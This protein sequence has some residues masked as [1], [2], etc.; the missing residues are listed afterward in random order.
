MKNRELYKFGMDWLNGV[1]PVYDVDEVFKLLEMFSGKLR[2]DRW[3]LTSSGKY[4][5]SRRFCLDGQ[6][7]IQL[8]Y[9]PVSSEELFTACRSINDDTVPVE[10]THNNS[11]IFFSISGDGIRYLHSL[12]GDISALN[13]LLFYFYRNNFRASRFD[14]YCDI[15]DKD[16]EIVPLIT[17][18]FKNFG[19]ETVGQYAISTNVQHKR[20]N[21]SMYRGLDDN[22]N[23][24]YNSTLGN[25]GTRFGMFRSYNKLVE[26]CD[27][28]L[29]AHSSDIFS[30]YGVDSYWYRLEYELHKENAA[31][32]FNALMSKAE[33]ENTP[34][35]FED[36]FF[37][38]LSKVF[39]IVDFKSTGYHLSD[40]PTVP[41][42]QDFIDTFSSDNIHFVQFESVPYIKASLS[43][44]DAN[45]NSVSSYVYVIIMRLLS[46]DTTERQKFFLEA[47]DKYTKNK[48]YNSLRDEFDELAKN[49]IV[50]TR[51]NNFIRYSYIGA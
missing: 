27:G 45:M 24:F 29:S 2:F 36:I 15:L 46:M 17:D 37:T 49:E 21:V 39:R 44:L 6:A 12:G 47:S 1:L 33:D 13:K 4:N 18:T 23:E 50:F 11:G 3:Q 42:W 8:M 16:N 30:S 31:K 51:L 38:V 28:R 43:R 35:C 32:C 10:Y 9:N 48:K 22:G 5:Y 19:Q 40:C 34:L 7:S 26:V 41:V 25:H 20:K 14:V